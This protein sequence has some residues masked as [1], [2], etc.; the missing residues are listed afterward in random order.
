MHLNL[1]NNKFYNVSYNKYLRTK[2]LL[3]IYVSRETLWKLKNN[4]LIQVQ[5]LNNNQLKLLII[6]SNINKYYF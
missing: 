5:T 2:I 4:R 1:V 3:E 6:K